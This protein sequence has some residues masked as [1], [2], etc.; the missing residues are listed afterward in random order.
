MNQDNN[1]ADLKRGVMK[2]IA[3]TIAISVISNIYYYDY[4]KSNS[5]KFDKKLF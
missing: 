2:V 1:K 3:V 5:D 4:R